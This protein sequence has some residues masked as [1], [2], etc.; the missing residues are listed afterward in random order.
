MELG[1]TIISVLLFTAFVP[2]VLLRIPKGASP[3]VVLVTHALLFSLVTSCVMRAYWGMRERF[4]NYGPSC[5][6]GYRMTENEG[7]IPTGHMTYDPSTLK[8]TTA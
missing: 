5:P 7:C 6:N 8:E 1:S 2:G 4:G 3:A